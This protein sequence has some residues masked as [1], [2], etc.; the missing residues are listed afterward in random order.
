MKLTR[1]ELAAALAGGAA[2]LAQAPG[3]AP[4]TPDSLAQAAAEEVRKQAAAVAKV[5]IPIQT[6]PAF[7]FRAQ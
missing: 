6:E 4:E 7:A 2:A 3:N 5:S 1:R